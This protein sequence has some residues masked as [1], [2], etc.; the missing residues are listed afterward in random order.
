VVNEEAETC[1][2][3]GSRPLEHLKVAIRI[4]ECGDRAAANVLIDPGWFPVLVVNEIYLRQSHEHR[5][6]VS[7]FKL[8][9]DT[10]YD[11]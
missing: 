8:G 7:Q 9:L 3:I 5:I 10:A 6:A 4:A 2:T 1:S 11:V